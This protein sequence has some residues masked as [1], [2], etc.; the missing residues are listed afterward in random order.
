MSN[1]PSGTD[2][3]Y[4]EDVAT[5]DTDPNG[6]EEVQCLSCN[7]EFDVDPDGAQ[8]IGGGEDAEYS[9]WIF[10]A[11]CPHCGDVSNYGDYD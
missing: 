10:D 5:E 9:W 7:K 8:Y 1:Y 4:F 2:M 11:T 3:S 6:P